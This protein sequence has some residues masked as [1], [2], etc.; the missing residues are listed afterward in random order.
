MVFTQ[1]IATIPSQ[2][3]VT[4]KTHEAFGVG[5]GVKYGVSLVNNPHLPDFLAK[6]QSKR[7]AGFPDHENRKLGVD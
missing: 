5:I 4:I 6:V 2:S 7:F 3:K 1:P